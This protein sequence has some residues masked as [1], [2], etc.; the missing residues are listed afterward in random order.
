MPWRCSGA[1]G[2]GKTTWAVQ[3]AKAHPDRRYVILGASF[4]LDQMRVCAPEELTALIPV[5]LGSMLWCGVDG[6][7]LE[8]CL[9]RYY[10]RR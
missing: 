5:V 7:Y 2:C 9:R 10:V 4:V 8:G 3:H 1:A 6:D